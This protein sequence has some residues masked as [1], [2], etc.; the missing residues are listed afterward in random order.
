[1][2]K[3]ESV[4]KDKEIY[5]YLIFSIQCPKSCPSEVSPVCK[6]SMPHGHLV[7]SLSELLTILYTGAVPQSTS[8]LQT[9]ILVIALTLT[10]NFCRI[11]VKLTTRSGQF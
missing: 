4:G 9:V 11:N 5:L 3:L 8:L 1:M 6:H 2:F 10:L 7:V